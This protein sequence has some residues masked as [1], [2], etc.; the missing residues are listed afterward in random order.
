M[1]KMVTTLERI[2]ADPKTRRIMQEE[3]FA[4]LDLAFWQ[5][6]V[7]RKDNTIAQNAKV[8]VRKDKTLAQKDKALAAKEKLIAAQKKE[9][10]ELRRRFGIN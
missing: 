10:D 4:A 7:A 3:E 8:L 5:D 9:L 1:K 6:V 2:A